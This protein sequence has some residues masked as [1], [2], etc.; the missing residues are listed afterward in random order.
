MDSLTLLPQQ[1]WA[2]AVIKREPGVAVLAVPQPFVLAAE[3]GESPVAPHFRP[4]PSSF[5][6]RPGLQRPQPLAGLPDPVHPD[7][8]TPAGLEAF[9]GLPPQWRRPAQSLRQ[10]QQGM[11]WAG[12]WE[13]A[14]VLGVGKE[15]DLAGPRCYQIGTQNPAVS[16]LEMMS[17]LPHHHNCSEMVF[18]D[19]PCVSVGT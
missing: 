11:G 19:D 17:H 7:S 6:S 2:G 12:G 14:Q 16:Y 18:M 3:G 13:H 1:R 5:C 9:A 10:L 8:A 4:C 15:G